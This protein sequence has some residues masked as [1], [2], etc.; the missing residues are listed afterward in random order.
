MSE[1]SLILNHTPKDNDDRARFEGDFIVQLKPIR[2]IISKKTQVPYLILEGDVVKVVSEKDGN[3]VGIG[4]EW[5]KLYNG[6]DEDNMAQFDDDCFTIGI[7]LDK[8]SQEGFEASFANAENK[9]VYL[10]AWTYERKDGTGRSQSFAVKS[11]KLI[12]PELANITVPF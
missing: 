10:R 6:Q 1:V 4:E 8:T 3:Q 5:S 12:T 2:K 9:L 7:S 11:K